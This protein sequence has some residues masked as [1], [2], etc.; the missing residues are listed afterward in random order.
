[1]TSSFS[2]FFVFKAP[3]F[4]SPCPSW[5]LL[6]WPC[7][8]PLLPLSS[9]LSSLESRRSPLEDHPD[10]RDHCREVYWRGTEEKGWKAMEKVQEQEVFF[11]LP[12]SGPRSSFLSLVV[13]S[14]SVNSLFDSITEGQPISNFGCATLSHLRTDVVSEEEELE[15]PGYS[16]RA[17]ST[18]RRR[19][20]NNSMM[21]G[22]MG[23]KKKNQ[24]EKEVAHHLFC[25]SEI[26]ALLLLSIDPNGCCFLPSFLPSFLPIYL[27]IHSSRSVGLLFLFFFPL[28]LFDS[29]FFFL[30][31]LYSFPPSPPFL[32]FNLTQSPCGWAVWCLTSS[33]HA[34]PSSS[35][36]R[37][38]FAG[39]STIF[40]W[41]VFHLHRLP[42]H[43]LSSSDMARV[44]SIQSVLSI[45]F[46]T[47][48]LLVQIARS[49]FM[50]WHRF[51]LR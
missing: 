46:I 14:H 43:P 51:S 5:L 28:S 24:V 13:A 39:L 6:S 50:A 18:I 10:A 41:L 20:Q 9:P 32:S 33:N 25:S 45:I 37:H 29:C 36:V 16:A 15:F 40:V 3:S 11:S 49:F 21:K 26:L 8:C 31:A 1:M 27:P 47:A 35:V 34:P 23:G 38:L 22:M 19:G 12:C 7:L 4:S 2:A 42:Y 48:H 17:V 30:L 44:F